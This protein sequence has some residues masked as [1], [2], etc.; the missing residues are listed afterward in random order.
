MD[1]RV[2]LEPEGAPYL[3]RVPILPG[4]GVYRLL[5]ETLLALGQSLVPDHGT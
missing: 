4:E 1:G 2:G 5:L 3:D